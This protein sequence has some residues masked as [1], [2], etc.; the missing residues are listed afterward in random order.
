MWVTLALVSG[1]MSDLTTRYDTWQIIIPNDFVTFLQYWNP[2]E[3]I[4]W[5]TISSDLSAYAEIDYDNIFGM[6]PDAEV[7]QQYLISFYWVAT[8]LTVNG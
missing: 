8:T 6:G 7:W 4:S 3:G 5:C 2:A 1:F